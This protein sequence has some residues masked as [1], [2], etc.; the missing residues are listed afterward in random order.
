MVLSHH[1]DSIIFADPANI[2]K[3][4]IELISQVSTIAI[5]ISNKEPIKFEWD[6]FLPTLHK[7]FPEILNEVLSCNIINNYQIQ[8]K[9]KHTE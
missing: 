5:H 2:R 8:M 1:M 9:Q 7:D 6:K 4:H 3:A